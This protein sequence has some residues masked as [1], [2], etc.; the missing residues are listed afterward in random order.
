V[1][2]KSGDK[3]SID[4]GSG[5]TPT[6]VF[7]KPNSVTFAETDV[8]T[9][10]WNDA[11]TGLPIASGPV[12]M[13]ALLA[14][15][16]SASVAVSNNYISHSSNSATLPPA[17]IPTT[18]Q[19]TVKIRYAGDITLDF[20]EDNRT[21]Y[22]ITKGAAFASVSSTGLVTVT[23]AGQYGEIKV[24][25]TFPDYTEAGSLRASRSIKSVGVD[26]LTLIATPYPAYTDSTESQT[27]TL[28][29]IQCSG[30]YQYAG[31]IAKLNLTD[32]SELVVS[33]DIALFQTANSA[34]VTAGPARHCSKA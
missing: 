19:L 16:A 4:A 13:F 10:T 28:K 15:I 34:I 11:C 14:K 27:T 18:L 22:T 23:E 30:L 6:S 3:V 9:S 1:V 20:T 32:G 25:V 26:S 24:E 5:S 7:L 33:N 12:R 29:Q 2:P 31:L 17:N 21:V 8:L